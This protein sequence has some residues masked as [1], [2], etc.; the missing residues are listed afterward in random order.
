MSGTQM[1]HSGAI[2][3]LRISKDGLFQPPRDDALTGTARLTCPVRVRSFLP[4]NSHRFDSRCSYR[5]RQRCER[6][7]YQ[8]EAYDARIRRGVECCHAVQHPRE[9]MAHAQSESDARETTEN[10]NT[11]A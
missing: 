8:D 6:S 11:Q 9:K 7:D 4:E 1:E 2:S 10:G 3:S 5:W